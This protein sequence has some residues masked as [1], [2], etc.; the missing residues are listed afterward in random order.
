MSK[1]LE[2]LFPSSLSGSLRNRA[3]IFVAL[4]ILLSV[5]VRVRL[6]DMPLERDEGEYAY[7]GQLIL[8]GVPPYKDAYNMKLPGTYLAYALIMAVL[9]QTPSG[10]HVGL[11]LVNAATIWLLFLLGKRLLDE[12]AGATAAVAYALM[13]LSPN[14]LGLA[15]HATHFVVL[16]AIGGILLLL[17]AIDAPRQRK[18]DGSDAKT[19]AANWRLLL[20][21]GILFGLAFLMKQHGLLFGVFG[22]LFILWV[23]LES[24]FLGPAEGG[25]GTRKYPRRRAGDAARVDWIALIKELALFSGGFA[26]PYLLTCLWLW[27]AGVFPQFWFWTVTYG[28]QYASGVPLVRASD[29]IGI[30]LKTVVGPNLIFWLLPWVGML[31]MWWDERLDGRR[32]FLLAS[33]F[34]CSAVSISIG[35]Y[36]REHYFIQLLPV[37]ALLIAVAV[38]RSIR[39]LRGDQSIELFLALA[40]LVVSVLAAGAVL[41]GNGSIWFTYAPRKAV[42]EI[43]GST[44]F[45]DTRD[46]AEFINSNT[47]PDAKIAVI[48]S[49]PEI[50]FYSRRRSATG[51]IYTYALMERQ[52]HALAMQEEFIREVDANRPE[53]VV[54]MNNPLSW[55]ATPESEQKLFNWWPKYWADNLQLVRTV[56]TRQGEAEFRERDPAPPGSSGNYLVIFK[57]KS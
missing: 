16:P 24:R 37:L 8:Q 12:P 33:L 41:I 14:V 34:V 13:S 48:G 10:I 42:E 31:M 2:K 30:M 36:F 39:L 57:R 28:S 21:S 17:R 20:L 4:A 26:L 47:A 11:A 38:S 55:L 27:A 51:H 25:L 52:P 18:A 56:T 53:Y 1:A 15:G 35:F 46:A 22:G 40:V 43:Y 19:P 29:L 9:G 23:R 32:R 49:E 5:A 44:V 6:R 7:A 54:H 50:Y 3:W 45:G